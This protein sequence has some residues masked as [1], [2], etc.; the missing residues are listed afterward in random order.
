MFGFRGVAYVRDYVQNLGKQQQDFDEE[1]NDG[2]EN[3]AY[4]SWDLPKAFKP[5]I[6]KPKEEALLLGVECLGRSGVPAH[7][8]EILRSSQNVRPLSNSH[9]SGRQQIQTSLIQESK[10][11]SNSNLNNIETRTVVSSAKQ[12]LV[13][14]QEDTLRI[15]QAYPDIYGR[16]LRSFSKD[17][18]GT[19]LVDVQ[20]ARS[21]RRLSPLREFSSSIIDNHITGQDRIGRYLLHPRPTQADIR[22]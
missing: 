5:H 4:L 14:S 2:S 16:P 8:R 20:S 18:V 9:R 6:N 22:Y 15:P 7:G 3:S 1:P 13:S 10:L 19:S 17:N 21:V 12:D 11:Q